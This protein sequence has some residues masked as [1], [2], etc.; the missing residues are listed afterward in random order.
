MGKHYTSL[1]TGCVCQQDNILPK[2]IKVTALWSFKWDVL[3]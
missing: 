3:Y 1:S 2:L